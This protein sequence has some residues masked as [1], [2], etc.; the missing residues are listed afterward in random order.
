MIIILNPIYLKGRP[1]S[2]RFL[3]I[4]I[5]GQLD[6]TSDDLKKAARKIHDSGGKIVAYKLSDLPR[7]EAF[8]RVIP[9]DQILKADAKDDPWRLAMLFHFQTRKGLK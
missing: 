1:G 2:R 8:V 5:T 3:V 7:D 6:R 4:F 9:Q